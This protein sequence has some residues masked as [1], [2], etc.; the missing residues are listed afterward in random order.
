MERIKLSET[1]ELSRIIYGMWR[2]TDDCDVSIKHVRKKIDLCLDQGITTI[3][4]ADIYGNY[5]AEKIFGKVLKSDNSLRSR[6]EIITKCGI[7]AP[8]GKFSSEKTKYYDTSKKHLE[9]SVECSLKDMGIDYI[10]LLLIHRPDPFMNP[11]ETA[12][13]LD[14]LISSGKVKSVG[15][16]NFKPWDWSL[17]Q[18]CMSN[19]LLTNQIEFSLI[20]HEPLTNGDLSFHT[21]G[22]TSIM[23]WS[24]LGGGKIMTRKG[25][26]FNTLLQTASEYHS[27]PGTVALAWV[28]SHPSKILPVVGTNNLERISK[29]SCGLNIKMDRRTW[30]EL[31]VKA[32]G[33][34]VA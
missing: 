20:H 34:D 33:K 18:S 27:D 9:Y 4:Q 10:D 28:L 13:T 11:Y 12:T 31:Y 32:M 2:L 23:A 29:I 15:T 6:L 16:S 14:R 30:Y 5:G 22:G 25:E 21:T 24:P 17:L 3:D 19:K 8:C 7:V 26:L 1:V